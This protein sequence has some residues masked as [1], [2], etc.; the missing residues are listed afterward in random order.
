MIFRGFK[1]ITLKLFL[2]R[3]KKYL[4]TAYLDETCFYQVYFPKLPAGKELYI[5]AVQHIVTIYKTTHLNSC[6]LVALPGC[7]PCKVYA[8]DT[9]ILT[10]DSIV[11]CQTHA[12]DLR[13]RLLKMQPGSSVAIKLID[14]ETKTTTTK[15]RN[16]YISVRFG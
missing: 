1:T 3:H 11:I 16:H 2:K 7:I 4:N 6:E 10:I 9:P 13:R 14:N 8:E 12:E 5:G 15:I